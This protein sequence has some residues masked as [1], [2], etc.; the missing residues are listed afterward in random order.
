MPNL[1]RDPSVGVLLWSPHTQA[2]IMD[3][4]LAPGLSLTAIRLSDQ[5]TLVEVLNDRDIYAQT[6]RIPF[7]YTVEAAVGWLNFVAQPKDENGLPV[8]WAIRDATG[9][10]IGCAGLDSSLAIAPHRA[11]IGY[12]LAKSHRGRGIVTAAVRA[13]CEYGFTVLKLRKIT[14]HVFSFNTASCR[15]LEKCG[16]ECEG[17]LRSHYL[18]DDRLH[19]AKAYGKLR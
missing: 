6:L 14:A 1:V 12:W 18:K 17:L 16:F 3:I 9:T 8:H 13:I 15:V 4:N 10:L 2:G 11:E 5:D 7:P 19:D